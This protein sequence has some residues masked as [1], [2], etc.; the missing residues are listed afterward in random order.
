[1][2]IVLMVVASKVLFHPNANDY[3]YE[4]ML[5]ESFI[6]FLFMPPFLLQKWDSI[7]FVLC[8]T[9]HHQVSIFVPKDLKTY[10]L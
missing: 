4:T 7:Y 9:Y 1:M 6:S 3:N 2:D 5:V 10:K 8:V